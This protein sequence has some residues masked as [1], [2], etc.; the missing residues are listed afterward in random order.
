MRQTRNF[1][2]VISLYIFFSSA[3]LAATLTGTVKG[4]DGAP[5]EGAFVQA[6]NA[7]TR[8]SFIVL[9]DSQG[10]YRVEKLPAGEYRV[11]SRATGF[12]TDPL[13][14]VALTENQEAS[15]D[16]ALL[17]APIRWSELSIYQAK[18][19]IPASTGKDTLF[20][21][22]FVCHGFQTRMA[23][24]RRDMDG[25][26]DRVQFMRD[27]MHFSLG[28]RFDDKNAKDVAE[29]LNSSFG[30]D[31]TLAKS[32]ADLPEYKNTARKFT[33]D[34][35]NIVYVEYEMPGPSR[36]PFSAAP[37]K[38]GYLWIPNFGI[39]NKISRLDPKTGVI[40]DFPVPNE[41]T[42]AVHSAV[43]AADG[44]VWLTE[45]GPNKLGRWDPKTQ[46]ITEYQDAYLPGKEGFEDGGSKHTV[47]FDPD[48]NA[49]STGYPLSRFD[50]ET[51]KFRDFW[52]VAGHTYGLEPDKDGNI[53][54]TNPGT[55]Q[56]GKADWK[57]LKIQQWTVPT[58][59]GY[60]RRLE[61]DSA[62]ILWFG[63]YQNG[64]VGR[65]DPKTETFKEYDL[66]GGKDVFPYGIGIDTDDHV[67]YS[68]YYMDVLGRIDPK[69]GKIS[70]YPFPHSENTIREFFRD[71]EG[72]MW[73]GSPSNNKVGYFY[74]ASPAGK[75]AK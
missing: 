63:E 66:P 20:A 7:K 69:T 50:R 8:M 49:W 73:Y 46:K 6:Q 21:R 42:A 4:P 2:A 40:E 72:R 37:G 15:Q 30:Q 25:W 56:I 47:R 61:F 5:F 11:T 22:C 27:A 13:P 1:L 35:L 23:S 3:C 31:A 64:K 58:K 32:P 75:S 44:S 45:Q 17:K 51:G 28:W 54:F 18:Q 16:L 53:W 9:S 68:S 24:M 57:T 62:G 60:E 29:F 59:D 48:G 39:A 71:S 36:M 14:A 52:E 41:G 19:L 65:F 67:W 10:R 38:D 33:G 34:A 12:R 26:Q 70:E 43:E 74:L 55:G